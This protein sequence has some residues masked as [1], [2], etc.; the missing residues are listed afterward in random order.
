MEALLASADGEASIIDTAI[1]TGEENYEIDLDAPGEELPF[2]CYIC[3]EAFVNPVITLCGHYFCLGCISK[4]SKKDS[5]CPVCEKPLFGVFN[6][7][8]KLLKRL[9]VLTS[10][11]TATFTS[12]TSTHN[13]PGS[14][15]APSR[16]KLSSF[17]PVE[18]SQAN[19]S[20]TT[21]T[22][23]TTSVN[24]DHNN[25]STSASSID[26]FV[27]GRLCLFGE[28]SDWAGGHRPSAQ[29]S[30]IDIPI[31]ATIVVGLS[32]EG[33]HARV[34]K[35]D[36]SQLVM[37]SQ[38]GRGE[39]IGPVHISMNIEELTARAKI[40][41]FWSYACG[42]AAYMLTKGYPIENGIYIDNY[43]T[44]LPVKKGLSSS[45]AVCVLIARAFSRVYGLGLSIRDEM[46]VAYQGEIL[47][48]SR[49]GR[50]DQACA[51][52]PYPVLLN[53]DG[54]TLNVQEL[55]V[56]KPLYCVIADLNASKCTVRILEALQ[57]GYPVPSTDTH[58][59]VHT[60]L[61]SFNTNIIH[62]AV[63]YL[64]EGNAESIGKLMTE[65]Q[66]E[67]DMVGKEACP[68]QLTAPVLH[69]YL[70]NERLQALSYGGK[71]VGSQ[72]DGTIQFIAKSE[73]AQQKLF[74][75]L[76]DEMKLTTLRLT[77]L[78]TVTD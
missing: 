31:G 61:G 65:A 77:M 63:K 67:F 45:A 52:G 12:N 17:Q 3:R 32:N 76:S 43:K 8:Q 29:Q 36:L 44:T 37:R 7:A 55:K 73:D 60:L 19:D 4:G 59:K 24:I 26:L 1:D 25:N 69:S 41:D 49:C 56:G 54:N 53:H 58:R 18:E 16:R 13:V 23:A 9:Q 71:G 5:K 33:L 64:E 66:N 35:I 74:E 39:E 28:H 57:E 70:D 47:T 11:T 50:M 78:P 2:A 6:R 30:G 62:K 46:E 40:G 68:D 72:G 42:V 75:I 48:P 38:L 20:I 21:S 22:A 14:M 34:H 15:A 10:S 27:P 51:Y